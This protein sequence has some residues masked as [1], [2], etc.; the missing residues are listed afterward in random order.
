MGKRRDEVPQSLLKVT[1]Q[2][3]RPM[4]AA[5]V[6]AVQVARDERITRAFRLVMD[7]VGAFDVFDVIAET[8][9]EAA[10]KTGVQPVAQFSEQS[11]DDLHRDLA[12]VVAD[13]DAVRSQDL[14]MNDT[15][16]VMQQLRGRLGYGGIRLRPAQ[17]YRPVLQFLAHGLI[18][19][20]WTQ[21]ATSGSSSLPDLPIKSINSRGSTR[22]NE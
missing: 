13:L 21:I 8:A 6:R 5:T 9:H 3:F 17:A 16:D 14:D 10:V 4:V 20:R 18:L 1:P 22:K 15:L 19:A 2:V 11:L 7:A 12:N